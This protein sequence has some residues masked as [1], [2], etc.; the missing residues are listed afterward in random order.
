[1]LMPSRRILSKERKGTLESFV[2]SELIIPK[3]E[4]RGAKRGNWG[5]KRLRHA[6]MR[7]PAPFSI[8]GEQRGLTEVKT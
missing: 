5:D 8:I 6:C 7:P 3:D 4:K 1:V 2:T